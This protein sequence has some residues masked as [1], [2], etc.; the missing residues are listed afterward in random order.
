MRVRTNLPDS[1][2]SFTYVKNS[3]WIELEDTQGTKHKLLDNALLRFDCTECDFFFLTAHNP[4]NLHC[5]VCKAAMSQKWQRMQVCF[6][7]EQETT[8]HMPQ[9]M[10]DE[11]EDKTPQNS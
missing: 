1:V 2:H 9:T 3:H 6:I 4:G 5:P 10:E 7:P 11:D 8:F